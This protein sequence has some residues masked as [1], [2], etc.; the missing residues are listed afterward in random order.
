M[1]KQQTILTEGSTR[2]N[3]KS[4]A[5]QRFNIKTP[6]GEGTVRKPINPPK[7]PVRPAKQ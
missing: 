6:Q 2:T 5:I 3:V 1:I 4:A 7:D